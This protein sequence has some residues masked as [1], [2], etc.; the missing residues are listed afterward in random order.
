MCSAVVYKCPVCGKPFT[1]YGTLYRHKKK[2]EA[3]GE[4]EKMGTSPRGGDQNDTKSN[5]STKSTETADSPV[6]VEDSQKQGY[7]TLQQQL[8][9]PPNVMLS[10]NTSLESILP[11]QL[12]AQEGI[13]PLFSRLYEGKV[14]LQMQHIITSSSVSPAFGDDG[15][16]LVISSLLRS[17]KETFSD[18]GSAVFSA[19]CTVTS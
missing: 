18:S 12:L 1:Q 15:P 9:Y 7:P 13:T 11:Q 14:I 10:P 17:I 3:N 19:D 5:H 4:F 6:I 2:H 16:F 8:S